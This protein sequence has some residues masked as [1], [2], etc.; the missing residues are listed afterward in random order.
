[1]VSSP[2]PVTLLLLRKLAA[3][4]TIH[5]IQ[6]LICSSVNEKIVIPNLCYQCYATRAVRDG[7]IHD[8]SFYASDSDSILPDSRL[9]QHQWIVRKNASNKMWYEH[10]KTGYKTYM[11]PMTAICEPSSGWESREDPEGK[12]YYQN[13]MTGK[14]SRTLPGALPLGWQEAKD[15]DGKSFFVHS[16]LQLASWHRPGEQPP[17]PRP[18][19][20]TD[21]KTP[22][23]ARHPNNTVVTNS[24]KP[25]AIGNTPRAVATSNHIAVK[26]SGAA[27]TA[28]ANST[29]LPPVTFQ[30][31]AEATVNLIDP[32]QGA[33]VRNTKVAGHIAA[34]G[35]TTTFK[36]IKNSDRLHK[37]ARGTGLAS[38]SRQVQ[39]AWTKVEKEVTESNKRALAMSQSKSVRKPSGHQQHHNVTHQHQTPQQHAMNKPPSTTVKLDPSLQRIKQGFII[40]QKIQ[41]IINGQGQIQ[42]VLDAQGQIQNILNSPGQVQDL[43]NTQGQDIL[44][45]QGQIQDILNNQ[46]QDV[47]NVQGQIQDFINAPGQ[48]ILNAQ[49]Q[50]QDFVDTQGQDLINIQQQIQALINAQAQNI[51]TDGQDLSNIQ[52]QVQDIINAQS[53]GIINTQVQDFPNAQEQ[54]QNIINENEQVIPNAPEQIQDLINS[55][56]QDFTTQQDFTTSQDMSVDDDLS[57]NIEIGRE[58]GIKDKLGVDVNLE[59]VGSGDGDFNVAVDVD[60]VDLGTVVDV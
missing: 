48:D 33:V 25:E 34:K 21:P 30:G 13:S 45:G 43:I 24:K 32:S 16:E 17:V 15:P 23:S 14:T 56:L 53:Q 27:L 59:E 5:E 40:G 31:A 35:V 36:A 44:N 51:N 41:N 12:I 38:A 8:V 60:G 49:G 26:P 20:G 9:Q 46:G 54:I 18:N 50:V 58:L 6:C 11:R 28:A 3:F 19:V 7:H 57:I 1:M 39:H 47:L 29:N 42:D 4:R 52:Q 37:F 2:L 10:D 55:Q 22:N